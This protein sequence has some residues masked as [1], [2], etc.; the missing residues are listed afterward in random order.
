MFT[1]ISILPYDT[2][3]VARV[4]DQ[5]RMGISSG[6]IAESVLGIIESLTFRPVPIFISK[7]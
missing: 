4:G 3:Q 1:R 6:K 2:K 7:F 5:V